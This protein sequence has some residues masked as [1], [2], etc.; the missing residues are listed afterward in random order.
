M[1]KGPR[2]AK[3]TIASDIVK[4]FYGKSAAKAAEEAFNQTFSKGGVPEDV[5]EIKLSKDGGET[6]VELLIKAGVVPSKAEWRR[7]IDGGAVRKEDD[8]K[9]ADPSFVL[10]ETT[11]LKIGKRRF[12]KVIVS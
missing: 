2:D 12:V 7:L 9:I 5:L 1:A 10:S 8:T 4:R 11:I 6:L 3:A